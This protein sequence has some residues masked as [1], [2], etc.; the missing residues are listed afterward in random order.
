M[1]G[2]SATQ[3]RAYDYA[4]Q[5][6]HACGDLASYVR[7]TLARCLTTYHAGAVSYG[8]GIGTTI[9]AELDQLL[10]RIWATDNHVRTVGR[11]FQQAGSQANPAPPWLFPLQPYPLT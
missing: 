4:A 2:A 11:R 6:T 9:G 5:T 8:G 1:D 10:T 3:Q 7:T